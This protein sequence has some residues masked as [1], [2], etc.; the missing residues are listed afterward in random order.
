M[1]ILLRKS[2]KGH[3]NLFEW[4]KDGKTWYLLNGNHIKPQPDLSVDDPFEV[5][6]YYRESMK[7]LLADARTTQVFAAEYII[8]KKTLVIKKL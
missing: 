5:F 4:S 3:N 1:R 2:M 8:D 6:R 7:K